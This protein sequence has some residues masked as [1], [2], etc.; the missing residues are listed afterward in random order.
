M[1]GGES[2]G[3]FFLIGGV[4][5]MVWLKWVVKWKWLFLFGLFLV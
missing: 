1:D 5:E 2:C 3:E 4:D